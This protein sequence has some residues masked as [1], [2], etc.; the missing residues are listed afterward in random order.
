VRGELLARGL[1]Q[2]VRPEDVVALAA[3]PGPGPF[4]ATLLT[5]LLDLGRWEEAHEACRSPADRA[6]VEARLAAAQL[7]RGQ[8]DTEIR[9]VTLPG[10]LYR[11]HA[12]RTRLAAL[13]VA[14][15]FV[16]AVDARSL[17]FA[18]PAVVRAEG[19]GAG[20]EP[21][22]DGGLGNQLS[23][24]RAMAGLPDGG[25]LLEDDAYV[26]TSA[27]AGAGGLLAHGADLVMLQWELGPA[28]APQDRSVLDFGAVL[29]GLAAAEPERRSIGAYGYAISA[30]GIDAVRDAINENGVTHHGYDWLLAAM[31]LNHAQAHA[32]PA[33]AARDRVL[34]WHGRGFIGSGGRPLLASG[35]ARTPLLEHRPFGSARATR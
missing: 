27:V 10:D 26:W 9:I 16:E 13:G 30:R 35:V 32:L 18:A 31:S 4:P 33:S 1:L 7:P 34:A 8:H 29:A 19:T 21:M 20:P 22:F 14:A 12:M 5:A 17:A 6:L 3:A 2:L 11:R 28:P 25:V 15:A 24:L 23:V